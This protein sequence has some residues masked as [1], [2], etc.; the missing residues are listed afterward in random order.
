MLLGYRQPIAAPLYQ[1]PALAPGSPHSPDPPDKE[2]HHRPNGREVGNVA[3][4]AL[5]TG[6]DRSSSAALPFARMHDD[7][8]KPTPL[9]GAVKKLHRIR[10]ERER[11]RERVSRKVGIVSNC[12]TRTSTAT[13]TIATVIFH[14]CQTPFKSC[15]SKKK[16]NVRPR[17]QIF[18]VTQRVRDQSQI[19]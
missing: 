11:A 9:R 6:A 4:G 13:L 3:R 12:G 18:S 17:Q 7:K 2:A 8:L 19:F 10:S 1:L 16:K 15:D 5:K 14:L